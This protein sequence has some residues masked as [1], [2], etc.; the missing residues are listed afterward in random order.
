MR[1]PDSIALKRLC[2]LKRYGLQSAEFLLTESNSCRILC[3]FVSFLR[4]KAF[5]DTFP[6]DNLQILSPTDAGVF[7]S[8]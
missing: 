3:C 2:S 8:F 7:D 5:V 6:L 4:C 1:R